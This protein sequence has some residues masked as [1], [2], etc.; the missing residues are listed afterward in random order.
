MSSLVLLVL[1]PLLPLLLIVLEP[2]LAI[3]TF[4]STIFCTN[5][6]S[7]RLSGLSSLVQPMILA[8]VPTAVAPTGI[9][10]KTIDPAP[11]FAPLPIV[12]FPKRTKNH[13]DT[14]ERYRG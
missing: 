8:G 4:S 3:L 12:M 2:P 7:T 13:D 1:L 10:F 6:L 9:D 5:E 11:I 14:M